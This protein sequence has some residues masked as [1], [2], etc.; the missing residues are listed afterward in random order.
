MA[1]TRSHKAAWRLA[2][3]SL[4]LLSLGCRSTEITATQS[5]RR[6]FGD[7]ARLGA[8]SEIPG[9][10]GRIE[11]VQPVVGPSG[12]EGY[13]AT[14]WCKSKSNL[15]PVRVVM[16]KSPRVL[17]ATVLSYPSS[18]GRKVQSPRFSRQFTGKGPKDPIEVGKDI[19]AVSGATSSSAAMANGV[20]RAVRAVQTTR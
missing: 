16:D 19:D 5:A 2:I 6:H 12:P 13:V 9:R 14:V 17:S 1:P 20:R 10:P 4:V 15:F 7:A 3:L 18:R 11:S 8:P